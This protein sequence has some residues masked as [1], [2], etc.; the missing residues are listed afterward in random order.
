M[1]EPRTKRASQPVPEDDFE[2]YLLAQVQAKEVHFPKAVLLP[3]EEAS[4]APG[5]LGRAWDAKASFIR[6]LPRVLLTPAFAYSVVLALLVPAYLGISH[7]RAS[8]TAA[9]ADRRA[10]VVPS[11]APVAP[12]RPAELGTPKSLHLGG[13]QVRGEGAVSRLTIEESD[14]FVLLSFLAPTRSDPNVMYQ[15]TLVDAGGRTVA[16]KKPL[17]STDGRGSFTLVCASGLLA[18]GDYVLSV[19]QVTA[20]AVADGPYQFRFRVI[21]PA[22]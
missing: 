9:D 19:S 5:L 16:V 4:A 17:E 11:P 12:V 2:R 21:R 18:Q 6:R 14:D 22:P 10:L 20:G 1:A 15:A 3:P 7:L 8:R 13:G